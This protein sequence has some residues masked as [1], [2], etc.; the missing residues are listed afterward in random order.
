M[1]LTEREITVVRV[2]LTEHEKKLPA[3]LTLLH[4]DLKVGGLTVFRAV[5]GYGDSRRWHSSS[6]L[7]LS[8]NLP[9][10]IEFFDEPARARAA[11]ESLGRICKPGHVI[12]W[13][14]RTLIA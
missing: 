13:P 7:D 9:I 8:L 3:L 5:T 4:D 2:Y 12:E 1:T 6:F 11:L 14:A 10:V